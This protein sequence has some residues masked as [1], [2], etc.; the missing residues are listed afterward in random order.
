MTSRAR[1]TQAERVRAD[2]VR[3]KRKLI[4][5][6]TLARLPGESTAEFKYRVAL[7]KLKAAAKPDKTISA[8]SVVY[9]VA[10]GDFV[11]IGTTTNL[12]MRIKTLDAMN[13]YPVRLLASIK[14]AHGA[15]ATLHRHFRSSHHRGEWFKLTDEMA[16][17]LKHSHGVEL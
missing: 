7:E 13:P 15:E 14:G 8:D 1:V 11:K 16:D 5:P 12:S 3:K 17:W 9:V 4:P 10:C 6:T 2:V